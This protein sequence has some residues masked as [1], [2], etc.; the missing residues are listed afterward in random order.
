M[1]IVTAAASSP[2][3]KSPPGAQHIS[4]G[5][6]LSDI[7]PLQY[8][9]VV[10]TIYRAVTGDVVPEPLRIVGSAVV[11]GL[12]GGPLGVLTALAGTA[13]EKAIGLDP[14]RIGH[15]LM[16]D[17]GLAKPEAKPGAK[18]GKPAPVQM[19]DIADQGAAAAAYARAAG[20]AGGL[21]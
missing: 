17:L 16:A 11:S 4:F 6:V 19:A 21:G 5:E 1:D 9:P 10:G 8:L 15:M 3:P 2:A 7:N 14:D 20:A 13:V 18:P 12:L